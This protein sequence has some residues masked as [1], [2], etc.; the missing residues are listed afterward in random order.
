VNTLR[1]PRAGRNQNL[2]PQHQRYLIVGAKSASSADYL[3]HRL[4]QK[5]TN[6]RHSFRHAK[7]GPIQFFKDGLPARTKPLATRLGQT[8]AFCISVHLSSGRV[9]DALMRLGAQAMISTMDVAIWGHQPTRMS[10]ARLRRPCGPRNMA[11]DFRPRHLR[12]SHIVAATGIP[13][14]PPPSPAT[15]LCSL[16]FLI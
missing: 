14:A 10:R 15:Q 16:A 8:L 9:T 7:S 4:R 3:Q 2:V 5:S 11:S 12:I 1:Q 6:G 13:L